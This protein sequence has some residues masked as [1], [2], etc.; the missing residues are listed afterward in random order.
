M[1]FILT[2]ET[3]KNN[4]KVS[5]SF[6]IEHIDNLYQSKL[7]NDNTEKLFEFTSLNYDVVFQAN[8][9]Y[10]NKNFGVVTNIEEVEIDNE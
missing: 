6:M 9:D 4:E 7:F 10:I 2:V 8:L 3:S 1:R 5:F